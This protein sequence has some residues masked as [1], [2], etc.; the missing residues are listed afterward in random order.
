VNFRGLTLKIHLRNTAGICII[1][2]EL[3]MWEI[4]NIWMG[5]LTRMKIYTIIRG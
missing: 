2:N 4:R 1:S 5:S 3:T